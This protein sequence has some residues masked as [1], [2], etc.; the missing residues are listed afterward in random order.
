MRPHPDETS[1]CIT[2][3]YPEV[4]SDRLLEGGYHTHRCWWYWLVRL[5]WG[6]P[7]GPPTQWCSS[8]FNSSTTRITWATALYQVPRSEFCEGRRKSICHVLQSESPGAPLVTSGE[9]NP[10]EQDPFFPGGFWQVKNNPLGSG[11]LA[12]CLFF[13]VGNFLRLLAFFCTLLSSIQ[14]GQVWSSEL[15]TFES[16]SVKRQG[17]TCLGCWG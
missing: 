7:T 8:K 14:G 11:G 16:G 3:I 15:C 9:R 6:A 1:I 2:H 10:A 12:T 4:P 13:V 17:C 5:G